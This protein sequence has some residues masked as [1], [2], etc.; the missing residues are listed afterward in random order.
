MFYVIE[1]TYTGPN[2]NQDQY[3]DADTIEI[4]TT[5]ARGNMSSE[6]RLDGWCGTTN[7]WAVYAHGEYDTIEK[8]RAAIAEKFGEVREE[9]PVGDFPEFYDDAVVASFRPGKYEPMGREA[10]AV[11]T[12]EA[13]QADI[14]AETTDERIDELEAEYEAAANS[15]G[16]TLDSDLEGFMQKRRQELR[17]ELQAAVE[18]GDYD[19][20]AAADHA[21]S[22]YLQ[23]LLEKR[24]EL[25]RYNAAYQLECESFDDQ[26]FQIYWALVEAERAGNTRIRRKNSAHNPERNGRFLMAATGDNTG[27]QVSLELLPVALEQFRK[28]GIDHPFKSQI[29]NAR[30][31]WFN[32]QIIEAREPVLQ[33]KQE[34]KKV[35]LE[36]ARLTR[37]KARIEAELAAQAKA[38]AATVARLEGWMSDEFARLK[39]L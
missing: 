3:A 25:A 30:E 1:T 5:P 18:D 9:D 35:E 14:A 19:E 24:D 6:V 20:A 29:I 13:I 2:Q 33:A 11:W 8:A 23:S 39:A 22:P 32:R 26:Q 28:A 16:Y 34:L 31:A 37:E 17:D 38:E 12:Y 21:D 7:D 4:R 27:N 36:L 15:E 10:T